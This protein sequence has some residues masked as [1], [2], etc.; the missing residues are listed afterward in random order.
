M[1]TL[2]SEQMLPSNIGFVADLIDHMSGDQRLLGIRGK[3]LQ[4]Q[5]FTQDT[6]KNSLIRGINVYTIP[7]L[8]LI[9]GIVIAGVR[10]RRR[11]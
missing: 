1:F 3:T 8:I 7:V 2:V 9:T 6:F 10:N 11:G 4:Y 5:S